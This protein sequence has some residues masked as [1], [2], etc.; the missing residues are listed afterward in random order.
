MIRLSGTLVP[1]EEFSCSTLRDAARI[2]NVV[3]LLARVYRCPEPR[4][5]LG[6]LE[7]NLAEGDRIPPERSPKFRDRLA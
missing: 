7:R 5:F 6:I 3:A 4:R 1:E 2:L